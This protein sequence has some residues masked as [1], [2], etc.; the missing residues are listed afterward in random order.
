MRGQRIHG[1]ESAFRSARNAG[2]A[3]LLGATLLSGCGPEDRAA[4]DEGTATSPLGTTSDQIERSR[5]ADFLNQR[6]HVGDGTQATETAAGEAGAASGTGKLG[7]FHR[8]LTALESGLRH[9]P[10]TILHLGDSHIASDRFTGDLRDMFQTRF[11]DAGRGLM[12]PGYPFA[13]YRARGVRFAKTGK[14][15]SANSFKG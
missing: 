14:W 2:F 12:M 4:R 13:Y 6:E 3:A 8:A 7:R 15:S 10:V 9:K 1:Q 11:G 5:K